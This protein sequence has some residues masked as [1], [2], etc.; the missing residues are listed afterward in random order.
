[1]KRIAII[2]LAA[3]LCLTLF[4]SC[5]DS[6]A[7][8]GMHKVSLDSEPFILYVPKAWT[9]NSDS[10]ISGAYFSPLEKITV[11]ARYQAVGDG[12]S[13]ERY[14]DDRIEGYTVSLEDY[15]TESRENTVLCGEDAVRLEYSFVERDVKFISLQ[16]ITE[17]DGNMILLSFYCPEEVYDNYLE[18]FEEII[19]VFVIRPLPE[20]SGD[21]VTDKKTPEGMKIASSDELEYRFYVPK[22]WVCSSASGRS[23][24]YLAVDGRPNVTVTSHSPDKDMTV[25]EYFE[26]CEEEYKDRLE[27]YKLISEEE[28]KVDGRSA[29]SYTYD[30]T[31]DGETYR[32]MQTV[33]TRDGLIYSITYT[34]PIDC[35]EE[36]LGDVEDILDAFDFR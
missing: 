9:D 21:D 5:A 6:D 13:L 24:A 16:M 33:I 32:L 2:I 20:V 34:A 8:D 22:S 19:D 11:S 10:G 35:F 18:Q 27:G 15:N 17:S 1:M 4:V 25:E 12:V 36:Y 28:I 30:L 7:P 29:V 23:E 31:A 3:L 14:V 26:A